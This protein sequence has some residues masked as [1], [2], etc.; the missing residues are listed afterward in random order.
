MMSDVTAVLKECLDLE[1]HCV[2]RQ[3]NRRQ[4][5]SI[6]APMHVDSVSKGDSSSI[7]GDSIGEHNMHNESLGVGY[8]SNC[9]ADFEG[10]LG[11]SLR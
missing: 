8:R 5:T 11:L 6:S 3:S 10:M 2:R 9:V 1:T 4:N 7:N